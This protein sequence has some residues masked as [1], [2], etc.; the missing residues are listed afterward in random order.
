MK[1]LIALT[2]VFLATCLQAGAVEI[3]PQVKQQIKAD[4]VKK[5]NGN[6]EMQ[7]YMINNQIEAYQQLMQWV[8]ATNSSEVAKNIH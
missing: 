8:R 3:P 7:A 2:F 5:W 1:I 6:Y 4:A